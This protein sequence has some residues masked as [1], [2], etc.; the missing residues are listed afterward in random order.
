MSIAL[1]DQER[2]L[3]E[4]SHDLANRFH[5]SYYMLDLLGDALDPA[6]ANAPQLLDGLRGTFEEVEAMIRATL[7]L[8]RPLE[9]RPLRVRLEDLAT[10]L[11]QH[12]GLREVSLLGDLSAGGS[13]VEVD[14]ARIS[15][16]LAFLCRAAVDGSDTSSPVV[17]ELEGGDPVG[18]RVH[19]AEGAAHAPPSS[20]QFALTARIAES[21]GGALEIDAGGAGSLTLRLPV[22]TRR[23]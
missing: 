13:E 3:S 6:N 8:L 2:V 11:R 14:P 16:A 9:L 4:V 19:R 18:L 12:V 20:L 5:R 10:S 7:S 22:A 1:D 17:V 21:H 15:E 23:T